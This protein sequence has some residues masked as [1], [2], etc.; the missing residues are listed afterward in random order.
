LDRSISQFADKG[1]HLHEINLQAGASEALGMIVD[2]E[3]METGNSWKRFG[4]IRKAISAILNQRMVSGWSV[5]VLVGHCTYFALVRRDLLSIFH[6]TY[7]FIQKCYDK[8]MPLWKTVREEFSAFKALMVFA[9]ASWTT[10][11]NPYV[12]ACDSSMGGFGVLRSEWGPELA[13]KVGRTKGWKRGA[14]NAR[15]R[16]LE[17]AGFALDA[18]GRLEKDEHGDY[19]RLDGDLMEKIRNSKLEADPSFP[20]VPA[21]LLEPNLWQRVQSNRWDFSEAIHLLEARSIVKI[22]DRLANIKYLSDQRILILNDNLAVVLAFSRRRARDFKLLLQVRRIAA[23][24]LAK[25]FR[26]AFRWI[27]SELNVA[28]FDS[29]HC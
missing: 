12:Y 13:G 25:D 21:K 15:E 10:P 14:E 23:V 24:S 6:A 11:W 2:T 18:E 17:A 7:S 3:L 26:F 5:E 9:F 4:R 28:D 16:S 1:L 22:S 19:I 8:P 29:R 27:P 20:E